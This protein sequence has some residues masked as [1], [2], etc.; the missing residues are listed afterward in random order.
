[1]GYRDRFLDVCRAGD[2]DAALAFLKAI[3]HDPAHQKI[4]GTPTDFLHDDDDDERKVTA[5]EGFDA[6]VEGFRPSET[7]DERVTF[8]LE[9]LAQEREQHE[10][11]HPFQPFN[12]L[13]FRVGSYERC[14]VV[15]DSLHRRDDGAVV[16]QFGLNHEIVRSDDSHEDYTFTYDL[17]YHPDQY[18]FMFE[19][20]QVPGTLLHYDTKFVIFARWLVQ[21]VDKLIAHEAFARF[22]KTLPFRFAIDSTDLDGADGFAVHLVPQITEAS[23]AGTPHREAWLEAATVRGDTGIEA[24]FLYHLPSVATLEAPLVALVSEH[25]SLRALVVK[26]GEV[27]LARLGAGT[28]RGPYYVGAYDDARPAETLEAKAAQLTWRFGPLTFARL[29]RA[30]GERSA[31]LALE[32]KVLRLPLPAAWPEERDAVAAMV[33]AEVGR[34]FA[35][36][37]MV[38]EADRPTLRAAWEACLGAL[39]DV[40]RVEPLLAL[41]LFE[42]ENAAALDDNGEVVDPPDDELL[43]ED[44]DEAPPWLAEELDNIPRWIRALGAAPPPGYVELVLEVVRHTGPAMGGYNGLFHVLEQRLFALGP[45][46]ASGVSDVLAWAERWCVRDGRVDLQL[47]ARFGKL[48]RLLGLEDVPAFVHD[49]H[50]QNKYMLEDFYPPWAAEAPKRRL[51]QFLAQFAADPAAFDA[52]SAWEA[53]IYDSEP[54]LQLL[55]HAIAGTKKEPAQVDTAAAVARLAAATRQPGRLLTRLVFAL[56]E[57]FAGNAW[58]HVRALLEAHPALDAAQAVRLRQART[59]DAITLLDAGGDA[60]AAL[61]QLRGHYPAHPLPKFLT[62]RHVLARDG[63][64]R[65]AEVTRE[66][67]REL[68]ASDIVYRKAVFQ[69]GGTPLDRW[70][71]LGP[72]VSYAY[73][74]IAIDRY[75]DKHY[76]DGVF[77]GRIHGLDEDPFYRAL[78]DVVSAYTPEQLADALAGWRAEMTF[79]TET[80]GASDEAL[81]RYVDPTH[82]AITWVIAQRLAATPGDE[83]WRLETLLAIWGSCDDEKRRAA[84][85]KL[86]W[87]IEA[88]RTQIVLDARVR[89]HLAWWI[90]ASPGSTTLEVARGVFGALLAAGRP[91]LVIELAPQLDDQVII[92]AFLSIA[93]AFQRTQDFLGATTLLA[94]I[95]AATSP[96][97]PDYVLIAGNLAAFQMQGGMVAECEATLDALFAKDWS[98]FDYKPKSDDVAFANSVLGGDLAA[99]YAHAFRVYFGMAKFN[100]ACL[101]AQTQRTDLAV[102][103]LREAVKLNPT[104]YKAERLLAEADFAPL[105]DHAGFTALITELGGAA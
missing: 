61:A 95:L 4:K 54:G 63:A 66:V 5:A 62:V 3:F 101:Y 8:L 30:V 98:R 33:D 81:C 51:A 37:R 69:Y 10:P 44:K 92:N 53:V 85:A 77:D 82:W 18:T 71:A 96:K 45:R 21:L 11:R 34:R 58:P 65:A 43:G 105:H 78:S 23:L 50:R 80:R 97:K 28:V 90:T 15:V 91:E 99:Q 79:A 70:D 55:V 22:P 88:W 29:L 67:L 41:A 103:T 68:A 46:A 73:L 26:L 56:A 7:L 87:P 2:W 13:A 27:A 17:Q 9:C 49:A 48:L 57:H 76:R 31:A 89:P 12:L 100:A 59:F 52:P 39:R 32:E 84:L 1:M 40:A 64:A 24:Q 14:D 38:P 20:E 16:P 35:L 104:L 93:P 102:E 94:R 60:W 86:L 6:M 75:R 42:R 47:A 25:A 36:W 19:G 83:P 72:S 74:R